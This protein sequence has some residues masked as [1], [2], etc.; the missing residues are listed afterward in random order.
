[1]LAPLGLALAFTQAAAVPSVKW[2]GAIL[3]QKNGWYASAEAHAVA[4]TVLTYQSKNGAW[5]KNTDLTRAVTPQILA[6]IES[7]SSADTIDNGATTTPMRF[8]ALV[9]DSAPDPRYRESFERGLEYLLRSQYPNGGFPQFFPLR[10]GYYSH[11]TYNDDA[12]VNVLTLLRDVAAGKAPFEFVRDAMKA[13]AAAA[14]A[15]G[16]EVILKTQLRHDGKLTAWCAQYDEK[17]LEPAWARKYEPPSLSGNESVGV[18]RFL[19]ETERVTPEIE[20]AVEASVAWLRSVAIAG[21]RLEEFTGP[22]GKKDRRVVSDPAAPLLWARFYELGTNRPIFLG[23]DSVVHYA[24]S[25]IESERRNGY[26]YYGVWPA[27]LLVKDYP[28]WRAKRDGK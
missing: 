19:M 18:T 23:R 1:V 20:A 12:T 3:D 10:E 4:E 25:E 16:I 6:G 5:P 21:K 26:A 9:N 2:G 17:T 27:K 14:V 15:R 7:T 11:I 13:R 8:L 22:D 28:R 24:L